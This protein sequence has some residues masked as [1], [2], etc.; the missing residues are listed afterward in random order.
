MEVETMDPFIG[1]TNQKGKKTDIAQRANPPLPQTRRTTQ[2]TTQTPITVK[3]ISSAFGT[4]S[5]MCRD[6]GGGKWRWRQKY[7]E[8]ENVYQYYFISTTSTIYPML[9]LIEV[10]R[11]V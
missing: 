3:F 7:A 11:Y 1:Y 5:A 4:L 9:V 10:D 8:M 2:P 6:G